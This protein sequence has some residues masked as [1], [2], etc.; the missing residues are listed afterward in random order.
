MLRVTKARSLMDTHIST[1]DLINQ[2]H[3]VTVRAQETLAAAEDKMEQAQ[4]NQQ[5]V[6]DT[7]RESEPDRDVLMTSVIAMR[8]AR[9]GLASATQQATQAMQLSARYIQ[10]REKM[11]QAWVARGRKPG[12]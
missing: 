8:S 6:L 9:A 7:L 4:A 11:I 10:M 1:E 3:D 2:T 5:K 12:N